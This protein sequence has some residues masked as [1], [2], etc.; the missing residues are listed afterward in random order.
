MKKIQ[1]SHSP[2]PVSQDQAH[3]APANDWLAVLLQ[4]QARL[5]E[6]ADEGFSAALMN[7]LPPEVERSPAPVLMAKTL[8]PTT[9]RI[10]V[11]PGWLAVAL[12]WLGLYGLIVTAATMLWLALSLAVIPGFGLPA[13]PPLL[14]LG[15]LDSWSGLVNFLGA[16]LAHWL[17]PAMILGWLAWWLREQ[18]WLWE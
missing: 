14:V 13:S 9:R 12:P 10:S 17:A 15:T 4:N 7:A 6:P 1:P 8:A 11:P 16:G 18:E 5:D 3:E 2:Q